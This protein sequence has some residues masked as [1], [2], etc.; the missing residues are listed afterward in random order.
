MRG[1]RPKDPGRRVGLPTENTRNR[2]QQSS[3]V[4]HVHAQGYLDYSGNYHPLTQHDNRTAAGGFR[5]RNRGEVNREGPYRNHYPTSTAT[6][7]GDFRRESHTNGKGARDFAPTPNRPLNYQLD[8][9]RCHY[10]ETKPIVKPLNMNDLKKIH[11]TQSPNDVVHMLSNRADMLKAL[12]NEKKM[13]N[14]VTEILLRIFVRVFQYKTSKKVSEK[15]KAVIDMLKDSTFFKSVLQLY[16]AHL[17]DKSNTKN[18]SQIE[19]KIALLSIFLRGFIPG[20]ECEVKDLEM[21]ITL[22][23]VSSKALFVQRSLSQEA[24]IEVARLKKEADKCITEAKEED[25][26]RRQHASAIREGIFDGPPPDDYRDIPILPTKDD[27]Q[28]MEPPFLRPNKTKGSYSNHIHYLDVQFRLLREDFIGPLRDGIQTHLANVANPLPRDQRK[29]NTDVRLYYDVQIDHPVISENGVYYRVKFSLSNLTRVKWQNTKRLIFGS[30]VCLS[31]DNFQTLLFGT[32]GN[33]EEELLR[34]GRVDLKIHNI[35]NVENTRVYTMVESTAFFES[36]RPVLQVLQQFNE[37]SI[38]MENYIIRASHNIEQPKYLRSKNGLMYD[39]SSLI[40]QEIR[41]YDR[42]RRR[43]MGLR[44]E[45]R[46]NILDD[47]AWPEFNKLTLDESQFIAVKAALTKELAVIQGPPGTGKTYIGLKIVETLLRNKSHWS[48]NNDE[49]A[50]HVEHKSPIMVIC[51]TNHALDQFLKGILEFS[52]KKLVRIGGRSKSEELARFNLKVISKKWRHRSDNFKKIIDAISNQM[53][54][55]EEM[56]KLCNKYILSEY[57]LEAVINENH[58]R[59]L[60]DLREEYLVDGKRSTLP[61]W[62]GLL[63]TSDEFEKTEDVAD[64]DDEVKEEEQDD[65]SNTKNITT[66]FD[67]LMYQREYDDAGDRK[68]Y[69]TRKKLVLRTL[70]TKLAYNQDMQCRDS[71]LKEHYATLIKQLSITDDEMDKQEANRL[72]NIRKLCLNNQWRLY[73]YWITQYKGTLRKILFNQQHSYDQLVGRRIYEQ[74]HEAKC[75]VIRDA[76]VVGMT[77]TGA[78]MNKELLNDIRPKIVI[79]EEAAEILEAHI[80]AYK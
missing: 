43:P 23:D 36:Y 51:Y 25:K 11:Q 30:L 44:N 40:K 20:L 60:Q 9:G 72:V 55:A 75:K 76:D 63:S 6:V 16:T 49:Y 29:R 34:H 7:Y 52:P 53:I 31:H 73:R 10:A 38:P 35:E 57:T 64:A 21:H 2:H 68:D 78:A 33:R 19:K 71:P 54:Q 22:L 28:S 37:E 80:N 74:D 41:T 50:E 42:N 4:K 66:E 15:I 24:V 13:I 59:C 18:P 1:A 69:E 79:V 3:S 46:I 12:L 56:I 61:T 67:M 14:D 65:V 62:L 32:V 5:N 48:P 26:K 70:Y 45:N 27:L 39:I 58:F 47:N 77:T 8:G 17:G